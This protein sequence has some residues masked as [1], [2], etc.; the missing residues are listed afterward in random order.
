MPDEIVSVTKILRLL[1]A[2]W[3]FKLFRF[4]H[5]LR[6]L[7]GAFWR[8]KNDILLIAQVWFVAGVLISWILFAA[9]QD[10][11]DTRFESLLSSLWFSTVTMTTVG[12]GDIF[13]ETS[14]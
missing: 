3:V 12:Y 6:T 13:P 5:G 2:F 9:E 4:S 8:I 7:A 14:K 1:K 10:T 11:A